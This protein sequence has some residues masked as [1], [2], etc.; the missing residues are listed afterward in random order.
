MTGVIYLVIIALWAA[1]LIPMWLRRHDQISEI[2]STARF[3]SAMHSL[4]THEVEAD[5]R[6]DRREAPRRTAP[7]HSAAAVAARRRALVLGSLS[8]LLAFALIGYLLDSAPVWLPL[9]AVVLVAAFVAASAMTASARS[10][11]PARTVARRTPRRSATPVPAVAEDDWET[12]NAWD[13]EESWEPVPA[14]LP[15]YVNAPA[16]S[17]TPRKIERAV[18]EWN[19]QAMVDAARAMRREAELAAFAEMDESA[20]DPD[21]MF[22]GR[23]GVDARTDVHVAARDVT[24][25]IPAI[26]Y[27]DRRVVGA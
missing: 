3:S 7:R 14:T 19:G 26:P 25:E 16:A 8:A 10:A 4:A 17:A 23:S 9:A 2:R 1:V 5:G 12:W 11:A 20:N 6:R 13:D 21:G 24:A 15:T 22:D 27:T 18:G